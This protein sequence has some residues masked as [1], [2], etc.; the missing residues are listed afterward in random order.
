MIGKNDEG[1]SE[2]RERNFEGLE[3]EVP[4]C[5]FEI[6]DIIVQALFREQIPEKKNSQTGN[7]SFKKRSAEKLL[8]L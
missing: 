1:W 3:N 4:L 8:L 6:F 7:L 5:H 2:A